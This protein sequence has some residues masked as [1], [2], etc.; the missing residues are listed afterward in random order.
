MTLQFTDTGVEIDTFDEIRERLVEGFKGIYGSEINVEE[1]SPDGERIGIFAKEIQD[2]QSAFQLLYSQ[3]DPDL[4]TGTFFD[5]ILKYTGLVRGVD[6]TISATKVRRNKSLENAATST[7]G[8]VIATLLDTA[9]VTDVAG[10]ENKSGLYDAVSDMVGHSMWLVIAG[11]APEA[12][13][14]VMAK[15]TT[16]GTALKGSQ[17]GTYLETIPR[18]DP[19]P[20]IILPHIM[21]YDVPDDVVLYINMDIRKRKPTDDLDLVAIK[22]ALVAEVFFI[23]NTLDAANL[24]EVA[25]TAGTNFVLSNMEISDDD[26]TFTSETLT[27]GFGGIFTLDAININITELV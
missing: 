17:T 20:D 13:A 4:G 22:N 27:P 9:G 6:E 3:F 10:Y 8:G 2:A 25:Y 16:G 19:I 18:V 26:I 15:N 24:Y 7:L 1:N 21:K 23:A 12:V 14:E 11:G 5:V